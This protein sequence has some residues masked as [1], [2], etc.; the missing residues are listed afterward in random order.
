MV[1]ILY[2]KSIYSILKDRLT[3][4][5]I[6]LCNIIIFLTVSKKG[7]RMGMFDS[8]YKTMT[9]T[10]LAK[11][12]D[13]FERQTD[14]SSEEFIKDYLREWEAIRERIN[15]AAR[16]Q[17]INILEQQEY[18]KR[19]QTLISTKLSH[20]R[21]AVYREQVINPNDDVSTAL[22]RLYDMRKDEKKNMDTWKQEISVARVGKKAAVSAGDNIAHDNE[23]R[24]R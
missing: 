5:V 24:Q 6:R 17:L 22:E 1:N 3:T 8:R 10:E 12:I 9:K 18:E 21:F 7:E 20:E 13:V 11:D 2:F 23:E 16:L 19:L 14:L 15:F 4:L